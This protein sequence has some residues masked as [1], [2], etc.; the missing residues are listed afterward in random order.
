MSGTLPFPRI[1]FQKEP[2]ARHRPAHDLPCGCCVDVTEERGG[3]W[4]R[5]EEIDP[6]FL[7]RKARRLKGSARVF[8]WRD[9]YQAQQG[10]SK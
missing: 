3:H 4:W 8:H 7:C 6:D 5:F 1:N 2:P 9:G 10:G